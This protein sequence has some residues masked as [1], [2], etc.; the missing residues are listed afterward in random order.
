MALTEQKVCG[1]QREAKAKS[2]C[3][4]LCSAYEDRQVAI[5]IV[6]SDHEILSTPQSTC[7]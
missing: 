4:Y 3:K 7:I 1:R 2:V 5:L 6:Y